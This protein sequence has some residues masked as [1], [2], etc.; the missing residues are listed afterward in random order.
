MEDVTLQIEASHCLLAAYK[1]QLLKEPQVV[2][3]LDEQKYQGI[4]RMRQV[5]FT[6]VM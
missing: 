3:E 2:C 5:V 4:T 6:R 1:T